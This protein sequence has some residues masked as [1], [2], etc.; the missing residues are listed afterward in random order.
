MTETTHAPLNRPRMLSHGTLQC[1]SLAISRP[2]YEDFL[3]LEV[4]QHTDRG[5]LLRKG[6]YLVIVCIERGERA[7]GIG[8]LNHWGLDLATKEDVDRAFAL[9]HELKD[10]YELKKISRITTHHGTYS[11]YFQDRDG[12]WWEFQYV[13]GGQGAGTGRYDLAFARGD[14]VPKED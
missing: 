2:F 14:F 13:G 8:R 1:R 4:V 5:V 11:F 3:G 7:V 12:N 6:G 10:K 9:A